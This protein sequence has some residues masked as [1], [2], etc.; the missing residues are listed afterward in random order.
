MNE[1]RIGARKADFNELL[2]GLLNEKLDSAEG[3]DECTL[4]VE[5]IDA[6]VLIYPDDLLDDSSDELLEEIASPV[7]KGDLTANASLLVDML[8]RDVA[9]GLFSKVLMQISIGKNREAEIKYAEIYETE[10]LARDLEASHRWAE[11]ELMLER[12]TNKIATITK[13]AF[14]QILQEETVEDDFAVLTT[15]QG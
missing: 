15:N 9:R 11:Y 1:K 5:Y 3:P 8:I 2:C 7:Y 4:R 12:R 10:I 6:G 14:E 13:S